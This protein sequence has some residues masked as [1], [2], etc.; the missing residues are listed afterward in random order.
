M[1]QRRAVS[2]G[3]SGREGGCGLDQSGSRDDGYGLVS[4]VME[5]RGVQTGM[6][7][8]TGSGGDVSAWTVGTVL[9]RKGSGSHAS[10]G[11]AAGPELSVV[12]DWTA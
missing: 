11:A 12:T 6:I 8:E 4:S 7:T 9:T 5:D 10:W 1:R 2:G 3:Q